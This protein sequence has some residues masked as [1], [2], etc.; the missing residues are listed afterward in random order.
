MLVVDEASLV[1]PASLNIVAATLNCLNCRPVIVIAGD[2]RQQQP[3][4]TVDGE[5][6]HHSINLK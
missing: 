5:N 6:L 2:K 1:F 3:L 4:Q